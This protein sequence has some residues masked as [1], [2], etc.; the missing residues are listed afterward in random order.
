MD[1]GT[2]YSG[3]RC[4]QLSEKEVLNFREEIDRIRYERLNNIKPKSRWR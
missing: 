4:R 2:R 3:R 1:N